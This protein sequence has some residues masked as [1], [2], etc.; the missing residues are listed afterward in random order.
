[1][2]PYTWPR[3]VDQLPFKVTGCAN[4]QALFPYGYGLDVKTNQP[5]APVSACP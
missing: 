5:L 3:S 2:L 4:S 1:M